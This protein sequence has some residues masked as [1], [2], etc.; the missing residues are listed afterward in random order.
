MEPVRSENQ[1]AE[2]A[3]ADAK[4]LRQR[5]PI[6]FSMFLPLWKTWALGGKL[7]PFFMEREVQEYWELRAEINILKDIG[8]GVSNRSSPQSTYFMGK[9]RTPE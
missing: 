7:F 4:D 1:R 3:V 5:S 6:I 2:T 8:S 9:K